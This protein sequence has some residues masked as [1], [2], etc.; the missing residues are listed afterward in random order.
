M[1]S[2]VVNVQANVQATG[3]QAFQV[4]AE[5]LPEIIDH[6]KLRGTKQTVDGAGTPEGAPHQ[7]SAPVTNLKCPC[8]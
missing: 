3:V 6:A 2:A 7:S 5:T 1:I 8:S 4:L